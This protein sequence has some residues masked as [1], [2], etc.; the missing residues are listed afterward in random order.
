MLKSLILASAKAA[1][2]AGV[3]A[4]AWFAYVSL[5]QWFGSAIVI[6]WVAQF[7]AGFAVARELRSDWPNYAAILVGSLVAAIVMCVAAIAVLLLPGTPLKPTG[8]VVLTVPATL[9]AAVTAII[10]ATFGQ[11]VGGSATGGMPAKD[12]DSP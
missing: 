6:Y 10:G 5:L 11:R 2:S 9:I 4:V 1:G 3:V 8:W 12:D 7:A